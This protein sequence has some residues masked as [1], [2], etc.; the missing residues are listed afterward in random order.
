M[1]AELIIVKN[2][3]CLPEMCYHFQ[4]IEFCQM[5][6]VDWFNDSISLVL[7]IYNSF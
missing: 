3:F 2:E 1:K 4:P 6:A 5:R 7:F